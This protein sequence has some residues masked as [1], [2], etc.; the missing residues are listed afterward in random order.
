MSEF[1]VALTFDA[2]HPD[3]PASP[4]VAEALIERLVELGVAATFFVQGRWAEAYPE[5]ARWIAEAG[6]LVGSHTHYHVRV[7]LLS[8][9]GL[10][11][12]V[13]VAEAVIRDIVGVDPRPWFRCPFGAGSNDERVIRVL[14]AAGYRNVGW[15]VA[16]D[17]WEPRSVSAVEDDVVNGVL[18]H[19]DGAV[20]LLHTWPDRTLAAV[21]GAVAR[22]RDAG[23]TFVTVDA[24]A[25]LPTLPSWM[26]PAT[27]AATPG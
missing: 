11:E 16:A 23:A 26:V 6:F 25:E 14:S 27:E 24:L 13:R 20:V 17:D 8:D 19:G 2:E 5:T 9:A 18:G 15:H 21:P 3:R 12:D 7:P 10:A 4:L 22:L 1:R